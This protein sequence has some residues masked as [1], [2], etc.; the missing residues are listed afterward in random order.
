MGLFPRLHDERGALSVRIQKATI[1]ILSVYVLCNAFSFLLSL[2][3]QTPV[4]YLVCG[5]V[6]SVFSSV[7]FFVGERKAPH[8]RTTDLFIALMTIL[9]FLDSLIVSLLLVSSIKQWQNYSLYLT[10]PFVDTPQFKL[11]SFTL[12]VVLLIVYMVILPLTIYLLDMAIR[13]RR[14]LLKER[15]FLEASEIQNKVYSQIELFLQR[16]KENYVGDAKP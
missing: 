1:G 15:R 4:F 5:L 9:F 6:G 10:H 8:V 13:L 14:I 2:K 16:E 3:Y 7:G 12:T 11:T